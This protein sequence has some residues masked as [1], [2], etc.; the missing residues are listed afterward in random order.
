MIPIRK[1]NLIANFF[2]VIANLKIVALIF[3]KFHLNQKMFFKFFS[4]KY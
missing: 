2:Y 4:I 3:E 1:K